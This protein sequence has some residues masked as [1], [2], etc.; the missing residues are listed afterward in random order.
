[1]QEEFGDYITEIMR[2]NIEK[3]EVVLEELTGLKEITP[4]MIKEILNRAGCDL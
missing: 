3:I 4:E 1:M 2:E